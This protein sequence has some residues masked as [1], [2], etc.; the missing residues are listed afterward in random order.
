MSNATRHG[1][2]LL[3]GIYIYIYMYSVCIYIYN[4]I[5][6][7]IILYYIIFCFPLSAHV[8]RPGNLLRIQAG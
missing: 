1:V 5:L 2:Y 8:P 4:I 6:Y 7:Y 3:N